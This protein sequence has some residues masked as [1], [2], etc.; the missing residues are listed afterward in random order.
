MLALN[1]TVYGA[2][3]RAETA[4]KGQAQLTDQLRHEE[5][6]QRA[7]LATIPD[8]MI[9]IDDKGTVQSFS[10]TAEK[11][12]GYAAAEV[13]GQNVK[14][15]MPDPYRREHDGYLSHYLTTGEARIIG[16]SR[17]VTACKKDGTTFPMELAIGEAR[18]GEEQTFVGFIRDLTSKVESE[19]RMQV[20]QNELLHVSRLT[21]MGEMA[22]ALAHELNQPLTAIANYAKAARRTLAMPESKIEDVQAMMEKAAAQSIRAGQIIR[23]LRDFVEHREVTRAVEDPVQVVEEA[24]ALGLIDIAHSGVK[25]LADFDRSAPAI[26]IDKIQIQQ[27]MVNLMRNAVEAMQSV[28][29]RELCV[30][31]ERGEANSTTISICDTGPG[32]DQEVAARLFQPFITTKKSGMGVGLSICQSIVEAHQGRI[33]AARNYGPGVTFRVNLPAAANVQ[34]VGA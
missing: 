3:R 26:Y 27:V 14:M 32:L 25:V 15:L 21:A 10:I 6:T 5:A 13:I 29:H 30:R 20:L 4:L 11:L 34:P 1:E 2:R 33:W 7:I 19:R 31:I 22:A 16:R 24:M 12:F 17:A 8:A 18:L 9:V 28:G 23:R